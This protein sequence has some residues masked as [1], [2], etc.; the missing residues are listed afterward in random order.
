MSVG[1][2]V[3]RVRIWLAGE[4]PRGDPTVIGYPTVHVLLERWYGTIDPL[5]VADLRFKGNQNAYQVLNE[6]PAPWSPV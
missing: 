5:L 3:F 4:H 1:R 2:Y 6:N